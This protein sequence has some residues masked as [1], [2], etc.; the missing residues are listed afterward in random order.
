MYKEIPCVTAPQMLSSTSP[1][2]KSSESLFLSA[3]KMPHATQTVSVRLQ[4]CL[5][6]KGSGEPSSHTVLLSCSSSVPFV[7]GSGG[8]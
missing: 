6:E 2:L 1:G 4:A 7:H 8:I 5:R 3:W